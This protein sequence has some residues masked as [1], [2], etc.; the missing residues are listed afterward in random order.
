MATR[1]IDLEE[2]HKM[3]K[4]IIKKYGLDAPDKAEEIASL[5][6]EGGVGQDVSTDG[7]AKKYGMELKDALVFIGWIQRV[8]FMTNRRTSYDPIFES[9][10]EK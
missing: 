1:E 10:L 5:L 2:H 7:L 9:A 3:F 4:G 8:E 6:T